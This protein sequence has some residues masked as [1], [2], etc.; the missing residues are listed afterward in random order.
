[1]KYLIIFLSILMC[2]AP[3][4][5]QDLRDTDAVYQDIVRDMLTGIVRPLVSSRPYAERNLLRDV[6][7]IITP[8]LRD[9]GTAGAVGGVNPQIII[10]DGFINGLYLYSEAFLVETA[11]NR[12]HFR[13]WYFNYYLWRASPVYEGDSPK[14]PRAWAQYE[15]ADVDTFQQQQSVFVSGA[16]TDVILH[17]LGHHAEGAFYNADASDASKQDA[18]RKA[19]A[20]ATQAGVDYIGDPNMLGRMMSVGYV[21]ETDRW[22]SFSGAGSHPAHV[23]RVTASM[24][25]QCTNAANPQLINACRLLKSEIDSHLTQDGSA[26]EYRDR[27]GNGEG[28]A[29][30]RLAEILIKQSRNRD[31]CQNFDQSFRK[32]KVSR[33]L[34]H[35]GWCYEHGYLRPP[36]PGEGDLMADIYYEL[37]AEKGFTDAQRY[38]DHLRGN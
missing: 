6:E 13:E 2:A 16:L 31:A 14:S 22:R 5:A 20:W 12:P 38:L 9:T 36:R 33:A 17:E 30:Y 35:I 25:H 8:N 34:V 1:M 4:S 19:D 37:A 28:F 23:E 15:P 32:A 27:I 10:S 26:Q 29:H 21:F 3:S 18:E 11:I 24:N 7:F